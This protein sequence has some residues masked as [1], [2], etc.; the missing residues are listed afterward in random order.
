MI[1]ETEDSS[2]SVDEIKPVK[3][4]AGKASEPA[5]EEDVGGSDDAKDD[6]GDEEEEEV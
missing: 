1:E 5:I 4:A 3:K 2:S 6:D